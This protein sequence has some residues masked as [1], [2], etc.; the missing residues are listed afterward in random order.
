MIP[1]IVT[2]IIH[3]P[4]WVWPL[5]GLLLFLGFRRTRD[6]M[7]PLWRVLMLPLAVAA[8][9]IFSFVGAGLSAL[10]V[11]LLGLI[12]GSV[13]GSY[14]EPSTATR[15]LSDGRVWLR[16]EWLSF[17]Q[18]LVVLV[19]RYAI[20]VVPVL[21]PTLNTSATWHLST[22]SVSAIL[23]GLFLG[24]TVTKLRVYFAGARAAA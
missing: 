22:L 4:L 1:L 12:F 3:T 13:A 15:R 11:M 14:L 23:S 21:A 16:G 5:Y 9:A 17:T 20:N 2:I 18:I 8:L 19:F 7:S 6:S 10:P 24:R